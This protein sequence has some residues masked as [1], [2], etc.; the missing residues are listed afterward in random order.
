MFRNKSWITL[1]AL[2]VLCTGLNAGAA[3]IATLDVTD[4]IASISW[5]NEATGE[6]GRETVADRNRAGV[7]SADAEEAAAEEKPKPKK[8]A[9]KKKPASEE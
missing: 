1:F 8:K 2:L 3:E 6:R 5:L 4:K 9:A 7:K